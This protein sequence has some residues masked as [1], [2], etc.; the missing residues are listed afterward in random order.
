LYLAALYHRIPFHKIGSQPNM[1]LTS[2]PLLTQYDERLAAYVS[3]CDK[4]SSLIADLLH[5]NG[6]HVHSITSRVKDRDSFSKKLARDG[7]N[8]TELG[9]ITDVVGLR[10][11]T[12][13]ADEVDKV[14]GLIEREFV[15]DRAN[16]VDKRTALDPDR[17]GYLS[18]HHIVSLS[19]ER[20]RLTEYKRFPGL[21]AE[22][23]TRSI[24]QHA[25]AEIEHD[26]GYKS[27]LAVPREIRRR[28]FRLA[29]LLE[30]GDQEFIG[31]RHDLEKYEATIAAKIEKTPQTVELDAASLRSYIQKSKRIQHLDRAVARVGNSKYREQDRSGIEES[32]GQLVSLGITSISELDE[33]V[34]TREKVVIE[35]ARIWLSD[36]RDEDG[37]FSRGVSLFYLWYVLLAERDNVAFIKDALS[38]HFPKVKNPNEMSEWA[39]KVLETFKQVKRTLKP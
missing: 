17:F 5:E 24:L 33:A 29:G 18:F 23:Q 14:A 8:Y 25:W 4:L 20:L 32:L 38:F 34:E 37:W 36:D 11:I 35:F 30:L 1:T 22:I 15:L 27:K 12:H 2:S 28:F 19:P 21:K 16:S 3:F 26:L 31:I 9:E 39:E 13:L 7:K 6:I 10:I